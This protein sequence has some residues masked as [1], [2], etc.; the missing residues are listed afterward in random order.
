M[1]SIRPYRPE[2]LEGLYDVCLKTGDSGQDATALYR[3][4]HLL[5]A[6]Y[7]APYGRLAPELAFVAE[8]GGR[9]AGYIVGTA[10]T[11]AFAALLE[12]RWW[13]VLRAAHADPQGVP[14]AERTPD[15][16]LERLFHKP[17]LAPEPVV[18]TYPAHLHINLLPHLQGQGMGQRMMDTLSTAL[19]AVGAPGLHLGVSEANTRAQRFYDTYGFTR[20]PEQQTPGTIWMVRELA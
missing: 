7:A 4:K 16:H 10:D 1:A 12:V 6:I 2:D 18:A 14:W 5:G 11:R 8:D 17:N 15:Q 3:D 20:F 9:V 19:K 13:P